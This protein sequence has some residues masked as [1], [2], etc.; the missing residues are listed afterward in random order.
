MNPFVSLL[1][2][3]LGILGAILVLALL[4][5]V[6]L[7]A[8]GKRYS[9]KQFDMQKAQLAQLLG[10]DEAL[11]ARLL[12]GAD[13]PENCENRE[14]AEALLAEYRAEQARIREESEENQRKRPREKRIL[15]FLA[16]KKKTEL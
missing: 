10:G 16:E 1:L 9:Q 6:V 14:A 4:C 12:D 2:I 13:L 3:A 5:S 15:A 11:A 7:L 8:A